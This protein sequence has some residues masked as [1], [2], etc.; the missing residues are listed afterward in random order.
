MTPSAGAPRHRR[1]LRSGF[2]HRLRRAFDDAPDAGFA[3]EHVMGFLGQHEPAGARQRIEAGLR[4]A[5]QLHLAVAIGERR[6]HEERQPVGRRL[7]EGAEHARLVVVAR[8]PLQQLLG[9]LAPVAAEIFV[10][11]I[12]H[13]PEMPPFLDIDLEEV[14]HVV[15]RGRGLAE[16]ALLLDRSR[17]SIALDD[18]Q[19]AQHRAIF[20]G[21]FLPGRLA[22]MLAE[23]HLAPFFLR[24]QQDAPT[25]VRHFDIIELGPALGVDRYGGAQID[26][27]FLEALRPHIVPPIE[28]A[29]MPALQRAQHLAILGQA[30][31]VGNL[32]WNNRHSRRRSW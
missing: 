29:G 26:E 24:R 16:M 23:I 2:A 1:H 5:L 21:H 18:D 25:I 3:D 22:Q 10:Q 8:A 7:V 11:E 12:D 14:A 6:E 9:L 32:W 15:E 4:K 28:I 27:R 30:D 19:A 31:I 20:A 17:L 13:C